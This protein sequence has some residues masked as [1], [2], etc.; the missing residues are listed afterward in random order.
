M[1]KG[2]I[3]NYEKVVKPAIDR[4]RKSKKES[5][6]GEKIEI[7]GLTEN[8]KSEFQALRDILGLKNP[9]ILKAFVA[10]CK[11]NNEFKR[12]VVNGDYLKESEKF[13]IV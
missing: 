4:L 6:K 10:F 7:V 9:E 8:D 3:N 2:Q 13:F 5:G 12:F 1:S 11:E